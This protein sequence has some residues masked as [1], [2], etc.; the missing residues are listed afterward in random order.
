MPDG[1]FAMDLAFSTA[2]D[3]MRLATHGSGVYES[4]LL[5][6]PVTSIDDENITIN[7]EL[8]QNYPNPFNPTTQINYTLPAGGEVTLKVF[9][10]LGQ[11]VKTL[12]NDF[13]TAGNYSVQFNGSDLSSGVYIYQLRL[14]NKQVTRKMNL[15]K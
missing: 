10:A 9:D 1:V 12:V 6:E 4:K 11:T 2:N 13:Q 7:F 5:D 8:A 14:G 15:V 3:V